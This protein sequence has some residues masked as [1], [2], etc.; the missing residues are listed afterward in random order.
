[1]KE[2]TNI[3]K[4]N[5]LHDIQHRSIR[6]CVIFYPVYKKTNSKGYCPIYCRITIK[7]AR[8]EFSTGISVRKNEFFNGEITSKNQSASD[9]NRLLSQIRSKITEVYTDLKVK[10]RSATPDMIIRILREG[11][12]KIP[13]L[14]NLMTEVITVDE[15]YLDIHYAEKTINNR[16]NHKKKMQEFLKQFKRMNDISLDEVRS[17]FGDNFIIWLQTTK[18]FSVGTTRK[19]YQFLVRCMNF[20]VSNEYIERNLLAGKTIRGETKNNK[21]FLTIEQISLLYRTTFA[22]P[23]INYC[24]DLFLFQIFTGMAYAELKNFSQEHLSMDADGRVWIIIKRQKTHSVSTIPLFNEAKEIIYKYK[25]GTPEF[26]QNKT[27][28]RGYFYVYTSQI[29]NRLLKQIAMMTNIDSQI[30]VSHTAR[31][32][33]ATTLLNNKSISIESVAGV[34]GHKNSKITE[35]Y[36]TNVSQTRIGNEIKGL[37]FLSNN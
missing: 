26:I 1:M 31:K 18:K 6:L 8:G 21:V 19:H 22:V 24:R 32:T 35:K 10:D 15:K 13:T 20:A 25:D 2:R 28:P 3:I 33:F 7:G 23:T 12:R 29:Y 34:L 5:A 11:N 9:Y 14:I 36:Y 17:S 4:M 30:M 16:R 27:I 37:N